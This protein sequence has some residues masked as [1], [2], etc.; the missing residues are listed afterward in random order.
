MSMLLPEWQ[1]PHY[2]A[3]CVDQSDGPEKRWRC[4]GCGAIWYEVEALDGPII[5]FSA[6]G[7]QRL[8]KVWVTEE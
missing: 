4:D 5:R 7:R 1:C 8:H 3:S 6:N 2:S